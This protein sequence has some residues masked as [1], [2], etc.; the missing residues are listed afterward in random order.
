M[1]YK[2]TYKFRR[3]DHDIAPDKRDSSTHIN[4]QN[5]ET[6]LTSRN[7][8]LQVAKGTLEL[9]M[10]ITGL[11]VIG[12]G[13]VVDKL[14]IFTT[15]NTSTPN[16]S[17][18]DSI[19][20]VIDTDSTTELKEIESGNWYFST[21]NPIQA[22]GIAEELDISEKLYWIDGY[23]QMR[24]INTELPVT[25]V[26]FVLNNSTNAVITA[27]SIA[28][29]ASVS[30]VVRYGYT[31]YNQRGSESKLSPLSNPVNIS[32]KGGSVGGYT[33]ESSAEVTITGMSSIYDNYRIYRVMWESYQ[34]APSYAI[35]S[36][37]PLPTSGNVTIIDGGL[38]FIK[39]ISIDE[40]VAIG[41]DLIIPQTF[42]SKKQRLFP[43]NYKVDPFNISADTRAFSYKAFASYDPSGSGEGNL[44]GPTAIPTDEEVVFKPYDGTTDKNL[45][46]GTIVAVA[47]S[48][49][50][51]YASYY[52]PDQGDG[53][54]TYD[55][56]YVLTI[57]YEEFEIRPDPLSGKG[58]QIRVYPIGVDPNLNS[59]EFANRLEEIN[60]AE[61][62]PYISRDQTNYP[63][64]PNGF[65]ITI[66][67][68]NGVFPE[69]IPA[70]VSAEWFS[71]VGGAQSLEVTVP[72]AGIP[73]VQGPPISATGT[74]TCTTAVVGN[75]V[76]L[77]GDQYIGVTGV[78]ADNTEF[79]IDTSDND[80]ATDL[81][82]AITADTRN[83]FTAVAVANVVTIT[84]PNPGIAGNLITF[85]S[86]GATLTVSGSGT[87]TGG[88]NGY[89]WLYSEGSGNVTSILQ[90]STHSTPIP[91]KFKFARAK[92]DGSNTTIWSEF[93][94]PS[95][96]DVSSGS[97]T[98]F[99]FNFIT[100]LQLKSSGS[101]SKSSSVGVPLVQGDKVWMV[102]Y[103]YLDGNRDKFTADIGDGATGAGTI[104]LTSETGG[105]FEPFNSFLDVPEDH[106]AIN[107]NRDVFKYQADGV[108]LGAEGAITKLLLVH[109]I[110]TETTAK[111]RV[112]KAG[113]V[114]R[115]GIVFYDNY[116]R[117][118]PAYWVSD[119]YI[120]YPTTGTASTG[121]RYFYDLKGMVKTGK[122]ASIG[123]KGFKFVYVK[124]T[125]KDKSILFQGVVQPVMDY[126]KN[127]VRVGLYPFP[128]VKEIKGGTYST[129]D[130]NSWWDAR[131]PYTTAGVGGVDFPTSS[132]FSEIDLHDRDINLVYTPETLLYNTDLPGT[133]IRI[134]GIQEVNTNWDRTRMEF[135]SPTATESTRANRSQ[136]LFNAS[137]LM[138]AIAGQQTH[139][140]GDFG[141]I[142]DCYSS[143]FYFRAGGLF[144]LSNN[145]SEDGLQ[146]CRYMGF[147]SSISVGL[148][149]ISNTID[150]PDFAG[151]GTEK[152]SYEAQF[153]DCFVIQTD[154]IS[155]ASATQNYDKFAS[156]A[157][158][159]SPTDNTDRA[160]PIVDVLQNVT[161]QYGGNTIENRS[162]NIY[163]DASE[164]TGLENNYIT[165]FGDVYSG[166]YWIPRASS[167]RKITNENDTS[168]FDYIRVGLE[169]EVSVD[170]ANE[171]LAKWNGTFDSNIAESLKALE[172]KNLISYDTIFSQIPNANISLAKPFNYIDQS[173]YNNR[174][175]VSD[176]KV[177]GELVDSWTKINLGT[178]LD[179]ESQYGPITKLVRIKDNIL[180]FQHR[181]IAFISILPDKQVATESGAIQLGK[182]SILD[183]FKYIASKS[184]CANWQAIAATDDEVFYIDTVNKTLNSISEQDI[185][186]LKGFNSITKLHI[187][188]GISKFL[189]A[190]NQEGGF[191]FLNPSLKQVLFRFAPGGNFQTLVYNYITKEFIATRTYDGGYYFITHNNRVFSIGPNESGIAKIWEHDK[192]ERGSYYGQS[193]PSHLYM[194]VEPLV[195]RDKVFDAITVL[196]R[197]VSNFQKWIIT[198]PNRTSGYV[199]TDFKSKFDIHTSHFPRVEDSNDRFRER[200]IKIW[201]EYNSK[202]EF[203]VDEVVVKFTLKK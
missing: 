198:S 72:H 203:E 56:R 28:L 187:R 176:S 108:T 103:G 105:A 191:V 81:A 15:N 169:S 83:L 100:P 46:T 199:S 114:Y 164:G 106:N 78:R 195:G 33:R 139:L 140:F 13:T 73:T 47:S 89:N 60:M 19:Y 183:D 70:H 25:D 54:A 101:I 155:W 3:I 161:S 192:G 130:A 30:A 154:S 185:S 69:F 177:A 163:I 22:I 170:L 202:G 71:G 110:N 201:L 141:A 179:L 151:T 184:G 186:T 172:V 2:K 68:E 168:V 132:S 36:E 52:N 165:L 142:L 148:D 126:T 97:S 181:G 153:L 7:A 1:L 173:K 64:N 128:N 84:H 182:G 87:L 129:T 158:T 49:K 178:Y 62:D 5:M 85:V 149:V 144:H 188:D 32:S 88:S 190:G 74:V 197:G 50:K 86:S 180:A 29:T 119:I 31:Q 80:T 45:L 174:V 8:S 96:V 40:F 107:P 113:E 79:S 17:S 133:D 39:G 150:E 41:S 124:R 189:S 4:V 67:F 200:N 26:D 104:E 117:N 135:D 27:E 44:D 162:V 120:P 77:D 14:Y 143:F 38:L 65:K 53:L 11:Y 90:E 157:S 125:Q 152:C 82:A 37:G 43:A 166:V 116:G 147:D 76:T 66:W 123:A 23:N 34:S 134:V 146:F 35:V 61:G 138:G 95:T 171:A 136:I 42:S 102:I 99:T 6:F 18:T 58:V 93:I 51:F 75:T 131:L 118:T 59:T 145:M 21:Q 115:V 57:P 10:D 92:T 122:L 127:S 24:F 175:T 9:S 109:T 194:H 98:V 156:E 196:K 193:N 159:W 94:T 12:H 48:P 112:F 167:S 20:Q 16:G 137:S 55:S 111:R 121:R 160:F 63:G 91:T